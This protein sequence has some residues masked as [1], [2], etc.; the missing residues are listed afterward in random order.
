MSAVTKPVIGILFPGEMGS[1]LGRLLIGQGY[2]V[3][4]TFAG[5]SARTQRLSGDAGLETVASIADLARGAQVVLSSVPPGVAQA[6]ARGYC[7]N[8]APAQAP[9]YVD[10][11]SIS[12]EETLAIAEACKQRGVRFVDGAI[13]GMAA[14]LPEAGTLYLSGPWANEVAEMFAPVMRVKVLG[15]TA[16]QASAFKMLIS[17]LAKGVVAL[18]L[19][20]ALA[21]READLL[22]E[23]LT[24]YRDA[25]PGIMELVDRLLPTY[26]MH[27]ARRGVE[28]EEV[29]RTFRGLGLR[30]CLV[31]AAQQLTAAVGRLDLADRKRSDAA[32]WSVPEVIEVIF[33]GNPLRA[34]Q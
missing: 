22:D 17:G 14:R 11:N 28:L 18:F 13:H 33:A 31:S 3:I 6:V 29:G 34:F 23:L 30:P 2:R 24:C 9:L 20:M 27:A 12:P 16:G 8:I 5:R 10:L 21:A 7:L 32:K 4:T 26:P 25:Y 15:E 1:T 19:E